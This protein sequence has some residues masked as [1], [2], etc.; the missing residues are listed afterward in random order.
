M[1]NANVT[2]TTR[3]FWL[4]T[5]RSMVFLQ[6]PLFAALLDK[7]RMRWKSGKTIKHTH[8]KAEMDSEA[9]E[10]SAGTG[11][12]ASS[13]TLWET[14]EWNWKLCQLPVQYGVTEYL[15]NDSSADT[16]PV[17]LVPGLIRICQRGMRIKLNGM[18]YDYDSATSD[19]DAGFQSLPDALDHSR[20]Y[21]GITSNTTTVKHWNGASKGL[22]YTD[23]NTVMPPS[24]A[25]FRNCMDSL[26]LYAD[27]PI[28]KG[29]VIALCGSSIFRRF[30]SECEARHIYDREGA[31]LS[32]K[33]GF[34]G[35]VIDGVEFIKDQFLDTDPE[36]GTTT[37]GDLASEW[38]FLINLKDW[39]LRIHPRRAM[40]MTRLVW[41]A[42]QAG[43]LDEW[44]ARIML[45]GNLVCH[46]PNGSMWKSYV[47]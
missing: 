18:A 15:Q 3:D 20:L 31:G 46:K 25:N 30:Q 16:S 43:G 26:T 5:V 37:V 42:E 35:M 6:M 12:T 11:L 4:R 39:E 23:R 21:G 40:K 8:Q 19:S 17:A 24:I 29:D 10:Y 38:M 14:A 7:R 22:T 13:K 1:A 44:L 36:S 27:E 32:A 45:A 28:R 34:T 9:Q 2:A 33:Y 47:L 41:Q